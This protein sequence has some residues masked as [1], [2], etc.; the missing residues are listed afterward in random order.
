MSRE[1]QLR[2][3]GEA[4]NYEATQDN[5]SNHACRPR[6]ADARYKALQDDRK[7]DA[8]DG[9]TAEH[10]ADGRGTLAA[11]PMAH[12]RHGRVEPATII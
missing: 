4:R 1:W 7:D 9:A 10:D 3:N 6:E 12:D 2:A 8:A 11:E 5:E